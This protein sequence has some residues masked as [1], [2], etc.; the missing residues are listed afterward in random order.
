MHRPETTDFNNSKFSQIDS[1][2]DEAYETLEL[3]TVPSQ[4]AAFVANEISKGTTIIDLGCG[5]G[6][7]VYFF[8]SHGFKAVG[9]DASISAIRICY[10]KR[11]NLTNSDNH[12]FIHS[13]VNEYLRK[14]DISNHSPVCF[15]SRFVYHSLD[16]VQSVQFLQLLAKCISESNGVAYLEFRSFTDTHGKKVTPDHFRRFETLETFSTKCNQQGLTLS[17]AVEG[18]GFAKWKHDDAIVIRA[19]IASI[20]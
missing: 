5:N 8:A 15:Y 20:Q 3:P 2:W 16:E 13:D 4:F 12:E 17:Y 7:D 19:V 1:Y 11:A 18:R 10:D 6:K 14:M 9:V